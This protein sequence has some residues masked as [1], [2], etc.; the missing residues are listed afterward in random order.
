MA[1]LFFSE[2]YPNI[3]KNKN[4]YKKWIKLIIAHEK[5]K[6]GTLNFIFTDDESLLKLNKQYLKHKTYTDII[7][8]DYTENE[9][10]VINGDIFISIPRVEENAIKYKVSFEKELQRV[11]AHG[12]LHLTG[13][14]DK[15][16][17]EK[18]IMRQKEDNSLSLLLKTH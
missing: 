3:L 4:F 14:S 12:V 17:T 6:L 18:A 10:S 2:I 1:V 16:E 5:K 15:I 9:K 13:Y 7:T 11:M 8:F